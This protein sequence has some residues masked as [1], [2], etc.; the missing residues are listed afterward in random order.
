MQEG[1]WTEES[2]GLG[3]WARG[4]QGEPRAPWGLGCCAWPGG[5]LGLRS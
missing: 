1:T 5:C 2:L 4:S 3:D